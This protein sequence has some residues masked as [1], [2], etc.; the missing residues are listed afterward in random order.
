MTPLP[1]VNNQTDW[2][3]D[4]YLSESGIIQ[5]TDITFTCFSQGLTWEELIP[6]G[7]RRVRGASQGCPQAGSGKWAGWGRKC[8][9]SRASLV[10]EEGLRWRLKAPY[11]GQ[12]CSQGCSQILREKGPPCLSRLY[13]FIFQP[14]PPIGQNTRKQRTSEP[15]KIPPWDTEQGRG[16]AGNESDDKG[17]T[18]SRSGPK[19]ADGQ[20]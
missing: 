2:V 8:C 10:F 13:S 20:F 11:Q 7:S 19:G 14:V 18:G 3:S 1:K 6:W 16:R 12:C 17:G 15:G 9:F 5:N 4:Q